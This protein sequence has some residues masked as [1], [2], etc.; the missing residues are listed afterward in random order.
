MSPAR[1]G[2]GLKVRGWHSRGFLPHFDADGFTQSV[3]LR[4]GDSVPENVIEKWRQML[5]HESEEDAKRILNE[6]IDRYADQGY[7]KCQLRLQKVAQEV[8]DHLL[9]ADGI[10]YQL[11]AWVIM[12]NHVHLLFTQIKPHT[13]AEIMH[14]LKSLTALEI[15]R[16]L[17]R[18]GQFWQEDYY[19]RW[20]R[21]AEHYWNAFS[22]I[23]RNP[24]KARLCG[25]RKVGGSGVRG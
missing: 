13:L 5:A 15:N 25:S 11:H 22:Y 12:P 2:T 3:T 9:E 4:L 19:D 1:T 16:M 18:E 14:S 7:G 10:S 20:I 24:V 8:A 23:E 17:K 6:R 21:N